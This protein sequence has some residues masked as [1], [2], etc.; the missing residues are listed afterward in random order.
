MFATHV[1]IIFVFLLPDLHLGRSLPAA[2]VAAAAAAAAVAA[3]AAGF[4]APPP[5]GDEVAEVSPALL[6]LLLLLP[7]LLLMLLG[8]GGAEGVPGRQD[9]LELED[10][11]QRDL[12]RYTEREKKTMNFE[13]SFPT[14]LLNLQ[15]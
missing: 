10:P 4:A 8:G 3:V 12:K 7:L 15:A 5:A 6:L 9:E 13:Q 11:P 2:A 1:S 14:G